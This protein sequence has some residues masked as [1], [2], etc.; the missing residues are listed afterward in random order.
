[1]FKMKWLFMVFNSQFKLKM[2]KEKRTAKRQ[3]YHTEK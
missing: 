3:K 2:G 1:M